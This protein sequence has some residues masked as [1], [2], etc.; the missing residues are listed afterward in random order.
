MTTKNN[1]KFSF[2]NLTDGV[3][4]VS[5]VTKSGNAGSTTVS[6][7]DGVVS[8]DTHIKIAKADKVSQIEA[9]FFADVPELQN[10]EEAEQYRDRISEEKNTYDGLSKKEKKKIEAMSEAEIRKFFEA[11]GK[12]NSDLVCFAGAGV[13]DHYSP[14]VIAPILSRGEFLTAYTPYQPEISQGTLQ[15]IFEL[16]FLTLLRSKNI[17][18]FEVYHRRQDIATLVP[19][20]MLCIV[21]RGV[22]SQIKRG[23]IQLL[24][25]YG[26]GKKCH[27]QAGSEGRES[28]LLP[29]RRHRS[30]G[31]RAEKGQAHTA[32]IPPP[33]CKDQAATAVKKTVH[34]TVFFSL[35]LK[36]ES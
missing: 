14:S 7:I 28:G 12:R 27:L 30:L 23:D 2:V 20:I 13:E 15:Y 26:N 6:I 4:T 9:K 1:G 24:C 34:R 16:N 5:A 11:L 35:K 10:K 8:G 25:R 21:G 18:C 22:V 19:A 17:K 32:P 3:Y 33:L 31:D 36:V 29:H